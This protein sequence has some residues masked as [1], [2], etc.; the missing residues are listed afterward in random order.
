MKQLVITFGLIFVLTGIPTPSQAMPQKIFL[1]S[2]QPKLDGVLLGATTGTFWRNEEWIKRLGLTAEQQKQMERI[3][4]EYRLKL[5]DVNASLQKEELILE[6][7]MDAGKPAPA[8]EAKIV[9]QFDRIAGARAELEK[10]NSRMLLSL[11]QVLTPE[12]WTML[13]AESKTKKQRYGLFK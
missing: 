4:Q 7:L 13:A 6:V 1:P 10:T 2:A 5:I 12:Q 3:F 8:D 9:S 11:F